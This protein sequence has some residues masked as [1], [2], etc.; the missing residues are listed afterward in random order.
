MTSC[1]RTR[2]CACSTTDDHADEEGKVV[3]TTCIIIDPIQLQHTRG[4]NPIVHEDIVPSFN[5]GCMSKA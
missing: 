4:S 5:S 2:L 1:S 3:K